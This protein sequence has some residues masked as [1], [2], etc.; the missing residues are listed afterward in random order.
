MKHIAHIFVPE[1]AVNGSAL[2]LVDFDVGESYA[3]L[4]PLSDAK[5]ETREFYFWFFPTANPD[6]SDEL[7]IWL[8]GGPGCSSLEGLFQENGPFLWQFGT[9]APYPNTYSWT[10]LTNVVWIEYPLGMLNDPCTLDEV[11]MYCRHWI[12]PRQ[13]HMHE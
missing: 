9:Y 10:N 5:N 4:L 3:G 2:P 8:N 13:A 7:L 12:Q 11:L 6:A 1:F